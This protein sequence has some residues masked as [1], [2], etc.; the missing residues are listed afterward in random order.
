[1]RYWQ[2]WV[3]HCNIPPLYQQEVI[4][5]A[6]ALKL[7]CFED[8]G[9]IVAAMTTSI[10]RRRAAAAPGTTAT[11]GC[12]TP[13]TRSARS[14]CSAT[15][16][17]ASSFIHY[18]LNIAARAPGPRARAALPRRR[19]APISRSGSSTHWPGYDGDGP[20][21]VGNGAALHTQHDIFGEMVL[22]LAPVFLDERFRERA[23]D[24]AGA[25]PARA[26]GAQGDR[27]RRHARRR[28]LGVPH[29]VEAAD[30]LEPDVLGGG[31]SHGADRR[32]RTRPA[33][34][35]RVRAR[36]RTG[37]ARRSSPRR[38]DPDARLPG[39]RLR[40]PRGR[41]GAAADGRRC[42]CCRATTRA[43]HGTI[44][45]IRD[46]SRRTTA[47]CT[48]TAS[49]TASASPT[50]AFIDLHVLAG[51]GAGAARPR[52][53]GA[54][55]DGARARASLS[56]LGL[57]SED[58]EPSSGAHVGQLPAGVLARRPDPRRVRGVAALGRVR[59]VVP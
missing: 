33:L 23:L 31:R 42:G 54:R 40:R 22:A 32:A 12:A 6:L 46:G 39:G 2:R 59:I 45:A 37:S 15:S 13:T 47:G 26:A 24:A 4:R 58:Y 16:R 38:C 20:V 10:P 36:R 14:A 50:V 41:R 21:R 48:A 29:R 34:A 30:L 1:M 43:L 51:R 44:D 5:S 18:L 11:A 52:R 9:A 27:G 57:L 25:R 3:K 17:S 28:H 55:R 56:P 7:H 49:T 53:R 35:R 19:H 8:T